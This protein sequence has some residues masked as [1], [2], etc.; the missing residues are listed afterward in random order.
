MRAHESEVVVV[1]E[2][3]IKHAEFVCVKGKR[4]PPPLGGKKKTRKRTLEG[5]QGAK[6]KGD[7]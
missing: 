7:D 1:E 2:Q 6:N 4:Y 5:G 3:S